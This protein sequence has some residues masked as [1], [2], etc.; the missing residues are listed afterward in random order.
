MGVARQDCGQPG[1]Q[2]NCQVAGTLSVATWGASL[3]LAWRS[4]LPREW[5][6]DRAR[7]QKDAV[8]E[9]IAFHTKPE[10]ALGQIRAALD[11]GLPCGVV[12]ADTGYG[13]DTR[14]RKPLSRL[15]LPYGVAAQASVSLW[16]PGQEPLPPRPG[17]NRGRPPKRLRP[18]KE[19]RPVSARQLVRDC[20]EQPWWMLSWREATNRRPKSRFLALRVRP[21]HRD[22]RRA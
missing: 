14:F 22:Y 12:P 9:E 5:A 21:A 4:Y 17:G 1:K 18:T 13:A 3:P 2:D 10:I 8:P 6:E 20:G 11:S 19:H 15:R 16:R 7:R